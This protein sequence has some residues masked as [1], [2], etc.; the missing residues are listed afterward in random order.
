M[1]DLSAR[2]DPAIPDPAEP[3]A[4]IQ[5]EN[6]PPAHSRFFPPPGRSLNRQGVHWDQPS[7]LPFPLPPSRAP[8]P[9]STALP[10]KPDFAAT[11]VPPALSIP[12]S[13]LG[14][15]PAIAGAAVPA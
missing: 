8:Q 15:R 5:P 12:A 4:R 10:P 13:A 3:A 14:V 6:R 11:P 1:A 9:P 2:S 7:Q